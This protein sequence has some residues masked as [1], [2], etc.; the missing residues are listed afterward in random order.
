MFDTILKGIKLRVNTQMQMF[1]Q[2]DFMHPYEAYKIWALKKG[3]TQPLNG[4]SL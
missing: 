1:V 2:T 3:F 4:L